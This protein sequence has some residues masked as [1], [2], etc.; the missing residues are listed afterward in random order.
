[1]QAV[2]RNEYLIK[3]A[4]GNFIGLGQLQAYMAAAAGL[5]AGELLMTIN[6]AEL[7]GPV[8]PVEA[9]INRLAKL[10]VVS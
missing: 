10:G 1:M 9:A 8:R 2:Y 7:D 5:E 3:R 4:Y 6:H